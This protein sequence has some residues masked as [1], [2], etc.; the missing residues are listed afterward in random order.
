MKRLLKRIQQLFDKFHYLT[1]FLGPGNQ[2]CEL[3]A[4]KPAKQVHRFAQHFKAL[5]N[6]FEN[7]I[8]AGLAKCVIRPFEIIQINPNQSALCG[9]ADRACKM[10]LQSFLERGAIEQTCQRIVLGQ[11][12]SAFF[13]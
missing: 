7:L 10:G 9:V 2:E 13:A 12:R 11:K 4:A 1:A 5:S 3:I 8:T 6:Q